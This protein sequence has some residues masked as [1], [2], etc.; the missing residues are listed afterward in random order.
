MSK[1]VTFKEKEVTIIGDFPKVN[2]KVKDF[3]LV[4]STLKEVSLKDYKGEK[5]LNIFPSIDTG[6]C[7][8]SVKKFYEKVA[9]LSNVTLLNISA[10]LPFAHGRFCSS[11][12]ISS[13]NIFNLSTFRSN[14]AKDFGVYLNSS[15]L[16]G[17]C[18]RAVI[19]LDEENKVKANELVQEITNE[20]NYDLIL[21]A[22]K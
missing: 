8:L 14:F 15:V 21:K 3:L 22:V 6:V 5:I 11:E 20:P 1:K 12:N 9:S 7:A 4:D 19:L 13:N 17:L 18:S 10:D 2:E 16:Q